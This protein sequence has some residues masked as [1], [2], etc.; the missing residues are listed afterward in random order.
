[1]LQIYYK[2]AAKY[3]TV[4]LTHSAAGHAELQNIHSG[5]KI[6][7]LNLLN[8]FSKLALINT[9]QCYNSFGYCKKNF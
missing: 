3:E 2:T 4:T 8:L 1:M 7:L 5:T 9:M 6:F